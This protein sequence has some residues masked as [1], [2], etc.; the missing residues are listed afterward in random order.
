MNFY[1]FKLALD[2]LKLSE[3]PGTSSIFIIFLELRTDYDL[4]NKI[5]FKIFRVQ[6]NHT[7]IFE[8]ARI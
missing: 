7:E 8:F 6:M 2:R 4:S 5:C 3:K 1:R